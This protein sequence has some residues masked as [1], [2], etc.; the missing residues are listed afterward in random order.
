MMH[1]KIR[2]IAFTLVA[3]ISSYGF[4]GCTNPSAPQDTQKSTGDASK[5]LMTNKDLK[6]WLEAQKGKVVFL[7][8]WATWCPP[9][10]RELPALATFAEKN[11]NVAVLALSMDDPADHG[12]EVQAFLQKNKLNL[13]FRQLDSDAPDQDLAFLDPALSDVL[14]TTYVLRKDGSVMVGVQGEQSLL[15]FQALLAQ[16]SGS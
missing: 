13:T 10:I 8:L 9:C 15:A 11:P 2:L 3:V 1:A 6:Q 12:A 4:T 5:L 14:P 16:A 7:N